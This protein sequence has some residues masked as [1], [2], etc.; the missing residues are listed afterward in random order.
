ML[1]A[2]RRGRRK[3][4]REKGGREGERE[5]GRREKTIEVKIIKQRKGKLYV[6]EDR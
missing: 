1:K 6:Q 3:G 4:G 5:G 2:S